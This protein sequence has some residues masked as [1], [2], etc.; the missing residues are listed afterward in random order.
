MHMTSANVVQAEITIQ[1]GQSVGLI[2]DDPLTLHIIAKGTWVNPERTS[3]TCVC[4]HRWESHGGRGR[5][6]L[7][8]SAHTGNRLHRLELQPGLLEADLGEQCRQSFADLFDLPLRPGPARLKNDGDHSPRLEDPPHLFY[9]RFLIGPER[10]GI[11][12]ERLIEQ[13]LF[14]G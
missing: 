6:H 2:N 12:R 9:S 3:C 11:G 13:G 7:M 14:K 1:Q 10:Q 8:P 5:T 4:P